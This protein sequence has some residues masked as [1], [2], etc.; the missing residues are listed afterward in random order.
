M[1][2]NLEVPAALAFVARPRKV[3]R[4]TALAARRCLR[5][6]KNTSASAFTAAGAIDAPGAVAC[7]AGLREIADTARSRTRSAFAGEFP[8]PVARSAFQ[9]SVARTAATETGAVSVE[10][11]DEVLEGGAR[12]PLVASGAVAMAGSEKSCEESQG[13]SSFVVGLV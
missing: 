1:A 8:G 5:R 4:S 7:E 10:R 2:G 13:V 9:R 6:F 12:H 3:T 11:T